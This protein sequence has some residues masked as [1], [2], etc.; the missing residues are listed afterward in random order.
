MQLVRGPSRIAALDV[1]GL[2]AFS[3]ALSGRIFIPSRQA[4]D[5]LASQYQVLEDAGAKGREDHR[6][7][8]RIRRRRERLHPEERP[9]DP[10]L[11]PERL[12][13]L[14][15]ADR[16]DL[17]GRGRGRDAA[18]RVPGR[19][20]EEDGPGRGTPGLG[21]PAPGRRTRIRR[22]P[23]PARFPTAR[24]PARPCPETQWW[25]TGASQPFEP[26]GP[27]LAKHRP[28]SMSNALLVASEEVDQQAPDLRRGP[29]GGLLLAR[30]PARARHARR[31]DRHTRGVLPGHR[32][33]RR[34]PR[35]GLRLERHV[36]PLG[37]RR[38]VRRD[39]VRRG[40]SPLP[41]QGRVPRDG[42]VRRG[43]P[44]GAGR[45]PRP[46]ADLPHD[47]ARPRNRLR[48]RRRDEGG[49]LARALHVRARAG[50]RPGVRR[51]GHEQGHLG[52][53]LLHR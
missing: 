2:D 8:R 24:R 4:E 14:G 53:E 47:R 37:H 38:L 46:A 25:T 34:R 21:Q 41:L 19:V 16:R 30:V 23:C 7:H 9:A 6:G 43:P 5:F 39:A 33:R 48:D 36:V 10:A 3:L 22:S 40:R 17:R 44:Q 12:R 18:R 50:Q 45:H 11:E 28:L 49:D 26:G 31:R 29:A 13:R 20:A 35:Q 32:L 51:P 52:E 42:D 15:G 1:P 27:K